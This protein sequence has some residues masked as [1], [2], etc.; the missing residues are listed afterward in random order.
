M[1]LDDLVEIVSGRIA[2]ELLQFP[3]YMLIHPPF[4][5]GQSITVVGKDGKVYTISISQLKG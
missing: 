5:A 4:Q 2:E 1:S 3:E